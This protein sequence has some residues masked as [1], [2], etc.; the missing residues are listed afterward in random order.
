MTKCFKVCGSSKWTLCPEYLVQVAAPAY[1]LYN[2]ISYQNIRVIRGTYPIIAPNPQLFIEWQLTSTSATV[3]DLSSASTTLTITDADAS[4][5]AIYTSKPPMILRINVSSLPSTLNLPIHISVGN[6]VSVSWGDGTPDTFYNTQPQHV[7]DITGTYDVRISGL[8]SRFGNGAEYVGAELITGVVQWGDLGMTQFGGAFYGASNL[9]TVPTIFV[10]DV[11]DTSYMFSR[12]SVFNKDISGWNVSSVTNMSYMFFNAS[13]FAQNL[14]AWNATAVTD[15][16]KMFCNSPIYNNLARYPQFNTIS[17]PIGSPLFGCYE[18]AYVVSMTTDRIDATAAIIV[19]G[20]SY[21]TIGVLAGSYNIIATAQPYDTFTGWQLVSTSATV[22][23]LSSASTTITITDAGATL[24][25]TF[26]APMILRINVSSPPSTLNLP[27]QF[28]TGNSVIVSWGDGTPDI[29]YNS[30]PQHVYNISGSYIITIGGRASRFGNTSGYIGAPLITD[31]LQWGDLGITQFSG[32]FYG[33]SNLVSV[34]STFVPNATDTSYMFSFASVFNQDISGWDVSTVTNMAY[35]F[36]YASL[37][38]QPLNSWDVS[39][40]TIM[41]GMFFTALTFNQPLDA[42]DV[43]NVTNMNVMFD[44]AVKFNQPLDSWKV[45]NVRTMYRMLSITPDFNQ[46]LNS[47]DVSNVTDM[48]GMFFQAPKFNQ[49]LN[50]WTPIKVTNMSA[51][52][53]QASTFNQPLNS[54]D[55]SKVTNMTVMFGAARAFNQNL[56]SWVATAVSSAS[57]M[58]CLC[59]MYNNLAQYPQFNTISPPSGSPLFGC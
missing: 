28:G 55:V 10:P 12:A 23:N 8:A 15:A 43:S 59:P 27:I 49:P 51:M 2:D 45:G 9:L 58:F 53:F 46:P 3:A 38:N 18:R 37:F 25:A 34:P 40:V 56:S 1:I 47:W 54:W 48:H 29:S 21:T 5:S 32:A 17:P 52:F 35:M 33:A 14:S 16:T 7:Y 31:V 19:E 11:S 26:A 44:S 24:T 42:W 36:T 41:A 22:A 50:S 13:A 20:T 6:I 30:T 57:Q 4:L 39:K